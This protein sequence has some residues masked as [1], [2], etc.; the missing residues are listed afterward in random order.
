MQEVQEPE[1]MYILGIVDNH[2]QC[3]TLILMRQHQNKELNQVY[4]VM[5]IIWM[6]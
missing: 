2:R 6:D 1:S 5:L 4:Q 3:L